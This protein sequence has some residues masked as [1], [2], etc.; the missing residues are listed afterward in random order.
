M[1]EHLRLARDGFL[2]LL[3][4]VIH[5]VQHRVVHHVCHWIST[6]WAAVRA[7]RAA[8]YLPWGTRAQN[9]SCEQQAM[10]ASSAARTMHCGAMRNVTPI[11]RNH[12]MRAL[13]PRARP[14]SKLLLLLPDY[15]PV[16]CPPRFKI[17]SFTESIAKLRSRSRPESA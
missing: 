4:H 16:G 7:A 17:A 11:L 5:A 10:V 2:N 1:A 13:Q 14:N 12:C 9:D 8:C 15:M 3:A 6:D